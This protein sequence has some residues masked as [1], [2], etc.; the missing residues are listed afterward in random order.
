MSDSAHDERLRQLERETATAA[1][2]LDNVE[3]QQRAM[4]SEV[5]RVGAESREEFKKLRRDLKADNDSLRELIIGNKLAGAALNGGL[6]LLAWGI[7][8]LIT[9]GGLGLAIYTG[10]RKL[11]ADG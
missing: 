11:W 7:G 3:G 6:R 10:V 4:W 8:T 9:L 5:R 2:R 1:A